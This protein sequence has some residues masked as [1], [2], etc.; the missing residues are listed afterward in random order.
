MAIAHTMEEEDGNGH[1]GEDLDLEVVVPKDVQ[2]VMNAAEEGDAEALTIA[3]GLSQLASFLP[4]LPRLL[5]MGSVFT[6]EY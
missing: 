5:Y 3:L 2:A 6:Y 4:A 1:G